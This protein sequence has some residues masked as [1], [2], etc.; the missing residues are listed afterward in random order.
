M[1]IHHSTLTSEGSSSIRNLLHH[2][3]GKLI[4]LLYNQEWE[5]VVARLSKYPREARIPFQLHNTSVYPLHAACTLPEIPLLVIQALVEA[6]PEGPTRF[7]TKQALGQVM[8]SSSMFSG[9]T[10]NMS[11]SAS[12][13]ENY[14]DGGAEWLPLHVAVYYGVSVDVVQ[15]LLETY[16]EAVSLKNGRGMLPLHLA[17]TCPLTVNVEEKLQVVQLL[18]Q[19]FPE[20]L[21]IPSSGQEG[22]TAYEFVVEIMKHP[23]D[24]Q[25]SV[26]ELMKPQQ[27]L[28]TNRNGVTRVVQSLWL[29]HEGYVLDRLCVQLR[30]LRVVVTMMIS[31]DCKMQ[32]II[33]HTR[34]SR[35]H[36][37]PYH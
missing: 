9:D 37:V 24:Q 17:V 33:T 6:D 13:C 34:S 10:S 25:E 2:D 35:N 30:F 31:Y 14:V 20:S 22:K 5:K 32:E 36:H 26:L 12:S 3:E 28:E 19:T 16:G 15:F 7:S 27:S 8:S 1:G 21:F 4:S 23:N 18:L 11:N 29:E